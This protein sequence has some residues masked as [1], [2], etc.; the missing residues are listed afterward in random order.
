MSQ[1]S[2]KSRIGCKVNWV[3]GDVPKEQLFPSLYACQKEMGLSGSQIKTLLA[4]GEI[5]HNE[6][7]IVIT[8]AEV[9][10]PPPKQKQKW[11]CE[12]CHKEMLAS[13]QSHH[14]ASAKHHTKMAWEEAK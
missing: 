10:K 7:N 9:P 4:G 8:R 11:T 1:K 13:S 6:R 2:P 14:L 3:E 12:T 5:K